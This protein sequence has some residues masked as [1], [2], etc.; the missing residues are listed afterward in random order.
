MR[1][2]F[3]CYGSFSLAFFPR[4]IPDS[5]FRLHEIKQPCF[6]EQIPFRKSQKFYFS[7]DHWSDKFVL[8]FFD[9][10]GQILYE[11]HLQKNYF[12]S[13]AIDLRVSVFVRLDLLLL[14]LLIAVLKTSVCLDFYIYEFVCF[15]TLW[16]SKWLVIL[17]VFDRRK[18][19][20][21]PW[22]SGGLVSR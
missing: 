5:N 1:F 15:D 4:W 18:V 7:L 10:K 19:K 14:S 16:F 8:A 17:T 13:Y 11:K 12:C 21:G 2:R 3:L 6:T 22:P 20:F 9:Q